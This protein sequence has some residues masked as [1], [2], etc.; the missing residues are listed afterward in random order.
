[1][2]I[3]PR[4]HGISYVGVDSVVV[5]VVVVVGTSEDR[6]QLVVFGPLC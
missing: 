3:R 4:F 6:L 1:M 5:V 2:V